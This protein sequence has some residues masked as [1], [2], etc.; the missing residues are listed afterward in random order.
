MAP[1]STPTSASAASS[2]SLS[3]IHS[4]FERELPTPNPTQIS[5][6]GAQPPSIPSS[7]SYSIHPPLIAPPRKSSS[8]SP[9]SGLPPSVSHASVSNINRSLS[10]LDVKLAKE[11][12]LEGIRG[13]VWQQLCVKI[14]PLFNGQGLKGH[15]EDL[16]EMVAH[17]LAE[18]PTPQLT[19]D[20]VD[21]LQ[22]GLYT[23]GSKLATVPDEQLASR[24]VEVWSF[25]FGTVVPYLQGV[26]LPIRG[27]KRTVAGMNLNAINAMGGALG[28]EIPDV[29]LLSLA[30]FRDMLIWP[31][32]E[33]LIGKR[34]WA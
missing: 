15:I 25:Y 10:A 5:P 22:T 21:L 3:T 7:S 28:S 17:W 2:V 19:L 27:W 34:T 11:V 30:V 9:V 14:L 13:N 4:N 29:R 32:R 12:N 33:R 24:L 26:F 6:Q 23:L 31:L 8:N 1:S 20:L 16:N 18:T